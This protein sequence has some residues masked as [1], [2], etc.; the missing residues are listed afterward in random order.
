MC[1]RDGAHWCKSNPCISVHCRDGRIDVFWW[2]RRECRKLLN[3]KAELQNFGHN[4]PDFLNENSPE[5]SQNTTSTLNDGSARGE[6]FE[7][8]KQRSC[9]NRRSCY[10]HVET[11]F[12]LDFQCVWLA[13]LRL[14]AVRGNQSRSP[15]KWMPWTVSSCRPAGEKDSSLVEW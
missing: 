10:G 12:G 8:E 4:T 5:F 6:G 3:A 15:L 11:D 7:I 9:Y 14:L 1:M 2:C 13:V